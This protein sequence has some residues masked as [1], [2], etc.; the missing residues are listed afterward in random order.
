M[1][2]VMIL[3][4]WSASTGEYLWLC[5]IF[6]C[7]SKWV[8]RI[9]GR[10][11]TVL[12]YCCVSIFTVRVVNFAIVRMEGPAYDQKQSDFGNNLYSCWEACNLGSIEMIWE[13]INVQSV[14]KSWLPRGK[15]QQNVFCENIDIT[16][17]QYLIAKWVYSKLT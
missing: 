12:F 3:R 9:T 16:M 2:R 15:G 1:C 17:Y 7:W 13:P 10:D 4:F 8:L 14:T 6:V 11:V 5:G